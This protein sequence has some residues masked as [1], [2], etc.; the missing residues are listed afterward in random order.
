[1]TTRLVASGVA[2]AARC[3]VVGILAWL[4][5]GVIVMGFGGG[6]GISASKVAPTMLFNPVAFVLI[7]LAARH[8]TRMRDWWRRGFNRWEFAGFS[9]VVGAISFTLCS[10]VWALGESVVAGPSALPGLVV[11]ALL[12]VYF[13]SL[14]TLYPLWCFVSALIVGPGVATRSGTGVVHSPQ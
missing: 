12:G 14:F 6:W 1:M 10:L 8:L 11:Q 9:I 13:L 3:L 2:F 7:A 4:A 5:A